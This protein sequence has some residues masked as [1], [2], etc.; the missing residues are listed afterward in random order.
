MVLFGFFSLVLVL[1]YWI[2]RAVV[3]FDQLIA[4]GPICHG[5][6]GIH[7]THTAQRDAIGTAAGSLCSLCLCHQPDDNGI[8]TYRRSGNRVFHI[9]ACTARALTSD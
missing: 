8:R 1:V 3:L 4:D 2:N 6:S 5:V 7:R 9:P